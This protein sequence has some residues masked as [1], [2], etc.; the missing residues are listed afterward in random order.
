MNTL[1]DKIVW[2]TGG[3]SGMGQ[4]G[5]IELAKAGAHVVLSGRRMDALNET[6]E[7]IKNAGASASIEQLDITD[8]DAVSAVAK[9]IEQTHGKIDILVNSAGINVG[10]RFWGK[11][12]PSDWLKVINTNLNGNVYCVQSALPIMRKQKKGLIINVASWAGRHLLYLAGPAYTA[13]KQALVAVTETINMEEGFN[14]IRACALCPGEVATA[15]LDKRPI[16]VSAKDKAR[17]VQAEDVGRTILFVAQSPDH[18]CYNEIII[19]PTWNRLY[20]G[21][22]DLSPKVID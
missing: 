15:I 2:I 6:F 1:N 5:A 8:A 18:V 21:G 19:S 22:E 9:R 13:S 16:P 14:G 12:S 11:T 17:M 20:A 10:D 4:S 3:G 7:I